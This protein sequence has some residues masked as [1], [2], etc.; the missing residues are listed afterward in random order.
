MWKRRVCATRCRAGDVAAACRMLAVGLVLDGASRA[1][2]ARADGMDRQTLRG[3][4][5]RYN[6]EG[7]AGLSDRHADGTPPLLSCERQAEVAE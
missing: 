2:A 5:Q 4:V 6:A 7:L 3:W 1:D